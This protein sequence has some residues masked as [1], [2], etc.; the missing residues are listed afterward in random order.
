MGPA[1]LWP[2]KERTGIGPNRAG[3][4]KAIVAMTRHRVIGIENRIPW[5]LSEDWK[6]F[7]NITMGHTVLMGRKTFES[8]GKP[9]HG[10]RNLVVSRSGVFDGVE[11]IRDLHSFDPAPFEADG[12][13]VFVIGGSEIYKKLL[14]R[15]EL[16]YVSSVWDDYEGDSYFP[17][18]ESRF[19]IVEKIVETSEFETFI[20]RRRSSNG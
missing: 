9:L 18:F 10:R 3:L 7:R 12:Q 15:C 6:L 16:L 11:M 13:D 4:M 5:R 8:I 19:E 14:D 1:A 2:Q 17:E 20:Y